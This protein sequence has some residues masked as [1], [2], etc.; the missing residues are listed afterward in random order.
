MT[1]CD[2]LEAYRRDDVA[3]VDFFDLL[4]LVRVHLKE[5][6]NAFLIARRSVEK[7]F[8]GLRRA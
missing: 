2:A 1:R 5:L 8:A 4:A 3:S 6:A 7:S